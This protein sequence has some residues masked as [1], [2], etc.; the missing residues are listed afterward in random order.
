[1]AEVLMCRPAYISHMPAVARRTGRAG[2]R[3]RY[4]LRRRWVGRVGGVVDAVGQGTVDGWHVHGGGGQ[5]PELPVEGLQNRQARWAAGLGV[6]DQH[7]PAV[8]RPG[9]VGGQRGRPVRRAPDDL[10]DLPG[11]LFTAAVAAGLDPVERCVAM[12]AAVRD[13]RLIH[14]A[15]MFGLMA[16]RRARTAGIPVSLIAHEDVYVLRK[17]QSSISSREPTS[18]QPQSEGE[19]EVGAGVSGKAEVS[20]T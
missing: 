10:I 5:L 1:M 18:A 8:A 7:A 15:N 9:G 17:P 3:C 16:V 14:R 13:G 20:R 6:T 2:R 4:C 11:E 19:G 12:L